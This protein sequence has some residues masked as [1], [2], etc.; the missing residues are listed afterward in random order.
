MKKKHTKNYNKDLFETISWNLVAYK[1]SMDVVRDIFTNDTCFYFKTT[2]QYAFQCMLGERGIDGLQSREL[3]RVYQRVNSL[4]LVGHYFY[5]SNKHYF[6]KRQHT[7]D[8]RGAGELQTDKSKLLPSH[9]E[10]QYCLYGLF[11]MHELSYW[12]SE[13]SYFMLS[14]LGVNK[15]QNPEELFPINYFVNLLIEALYDMYRQVFTDQPL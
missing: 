6:K 13:W 14:A 2:I 5:K 7:V 1:E 8:G 11:R 9:A 10:S 3:F 12:K 15:T 4:L